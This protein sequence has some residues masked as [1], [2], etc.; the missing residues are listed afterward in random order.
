MVR[1]TVHQAK[2]L[3]PRGRQI[4][5]F[6]Q[7]SLDST[8][9]HRT[10]TLKRTPNPV[11]EHPIEFLVTNRSKALITIK[12]LDDSIISSDAGLGLARIKLADLLLPSA[13]ERDW[14]P[15]NG[16][17]SGRVRVSAEWKPVLMVGAGINGSGVYTPPIG[18]LR[19]WFQ[20][21]RDLKNVEGL[22]GGKS[23]PYIRVL[24]NGIVL[25]RTL[26]INNN[27][28]PEWDE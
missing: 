10:Q 17:K 13:K 7:I 12:L 5:P 23:D 26:V 2:D 28:N 9:V 14:F 21:G 1:L 25:G 18:T 6:A 15:L 20:K 8:V 22:T 11:F 19:I 4:N 16:A 3:D 24:R 27:L